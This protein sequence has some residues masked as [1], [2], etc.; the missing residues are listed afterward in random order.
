VHV[1]I[2]PSSPGSPGPHDA[3]GLPGGKR[4]YNLGY[5]AAVA[6]FA[7]AGGFLFG[8]D[9]AIIAGMLPYLVRDFELT[10]AMAGWAAGSATMGAILGP[11]VGL[12]FAEAIGR[13]RTMMLSA[14][15]FLFSTVGCYLAPS[16]GHFAFWRLVGGMGV[17]LAM[18]SCPI[19]I[20]ELSPAPLRGVLVNVNQ[21]VGVIGINLAVVVGYVVGAYNGDWRLMIATQAVPA[22]ILFIGLMFLPESPRWLAAKGMHARALEVLTRINGAAHARVELDQIVKDVSHA[23]SGL[24]EVFKP[25]CRKPLI[26]SIILM[27]F[28]QVNGVNMILLY[29]PTIL[30]D[31]GISFG[32]NAVLSSIPTYLMIFVAT[33]VSFPLIHRYSRRGLLIFS[34]LGMALGHV[35]MAVL[36]AVHAP[37]LSVLIP[38]M[39]CAGTFTIGLAPLS[40]IIVS[41][42]FPNRVRSHA[43]AIVCVFLFGSSFVTVQLFPMV[44]D[45]LRHATGTPAGMYLG[46]AAICV[47]CALFVWRKMPET[48][49]L[50]LEEMS[51]FWRSR[52]PQSPESA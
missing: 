37:A 9:L 4:T 13:R 19:Y 28:S 27:I 7:S 11:L 44:M 18:I 39:I 15:A 34:V 21:L 17:G 38:M 14:L 51:A 50:S 31:A 36:L 26:A 23:A 10:P 48:K 8:F 47:S 22:G 43:L 42:I 30:Q 29:G 46:F 3:S 16:I 41:E 24:S 52:A 49:G 33:L 25:Y 1:S 20:A 35:L 40:W 6:C 2:D 5:A 32:A 12:W 45:W